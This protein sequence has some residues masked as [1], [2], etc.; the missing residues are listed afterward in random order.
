MKKLLI[1][2]LMFLLVVSGCSNTLDQNLN[3]DCDYQTTKVNVTT[4]MSI[5]D[6]KE[7]ITN[8]YK[9]A[10]YDVEVIQIGFYLRVGSGFFSDDDDYYEIAVLGPVDIETGEVVDKILIEFDL[11]EVGVE[12]LMHVLL[13]VNGQESEISQKIVVTK[14]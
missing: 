14:D 3:N 4:E 6:L 8:L 7:Q 13:L 9:F 12:Y 10:G 5:S 2:I 1:I 11:L